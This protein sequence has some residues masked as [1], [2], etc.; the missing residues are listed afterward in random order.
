MSKIALIQ[1]ISD[2][3]MPNLLP[4]LA[5]TPARLLHLTSERTVPRAAR[6]VEA[7]AKAGILT[8]HETIRLGRMPSIAETQRE[9]GRAAEVAGRDGLRPVLNFTGGTKLMSIGAHAAARAGGFP[10]FYVD[11]AEHFFEDGCTAPGLLDLFDGDLSFARLTGRL[12]LDVIVVANG[13]RAISAGKD[14][15]PLVPAARWLLEHPEEEELIHA[16]IHGRHGLCPN[17]AE[18]RTAAGWV[19]LLDA[20]FDLPP[21]LGAALAALGMVRFDSSGRGAL[22]DRTRAELHALDTGERLPAFR[23][24]YFAAVSPFQEIIGFLSGGWWELILADAAY[25]SGRFADL[26]WSAHV[27]QQSGS[28]LEEDLVGLDGVEAAC[29]SCKRGRGRQR[30]LVHLEEFQ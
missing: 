9:V 22:P 18:P 24:R 6:I 28:S 11:T 19:K 10:S 21:A 27:I 25:R 2:Q 20:A 5:L 7:A 14:W 12:N 29:I 13:H 4:I 16:G 15:R 26:R 17:G 8:P 30:L 23:E 3:A 1:L